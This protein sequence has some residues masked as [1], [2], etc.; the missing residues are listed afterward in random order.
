[1]PYLKPSTS[2]KAPSAQ[3]PAFEAEV[4]EHLD[5]LY[6]VAFRLVKE[7]SA[8]EDLVHDTIIKAVRAR[9]QYQP[10]TNLKAW[11]LRILTN[12]F[13]NRHRR[14]GLERDILEGPDASPLADRWIGASTMR[15]MR[16][17]EGEALAP[18]V[19][20]EVRQA[21]DELPE[22]FRLA[23]VLS[24]VE[25]L[26]YKEIAEVMGCPVGTVMSRLH[27]A[28]KLLQ[29]SLRDQAIALGIIADD[30]DDPMAQGRAAVGDRH[31]TVDLEAYRAARRKAGSP[32]NRGGVR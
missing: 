25:G 20:A 5:A 18:L 28:R 1:M 4:L 30:D 16:D 7:A 19:E 11:L 22:E 26:A 31:E 29:S 17:P 24:D 32:P 8:A 21:L 10:G 14:G 2:P 6:G 27:R 13:I 15:A 9:S 12:T 23:I 3:L